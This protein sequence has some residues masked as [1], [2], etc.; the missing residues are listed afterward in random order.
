MIFVADESVDQPIVAV[1]RQNGHHVT[2]VAEH[3]PSISDDEVLTAANSQAAVL[4]TAD[5]DFG[6]MIFR[7]G[8][9]HAGVVLIRL[10]G[11]G[12]AVSKHGSEFV[13]SF[14]VITAGL[15]RIRHQP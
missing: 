1:L 10:S 15:V 3:S 6:E 11:L 7:Q 4:L 8:R 2:Y 14:S 12:A 13:G 5:K 9:A